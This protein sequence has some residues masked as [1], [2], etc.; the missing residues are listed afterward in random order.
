MPKSIL[1]IQGHPD[2]E[3]R[4]FGHALAESYHAGAAEAGHTVVEIAIATLELPLLRRAEDWAQPTTL[5][6]M[7][8]A[9]K[10]IAAANHLVFIYP[11]WLGDMPAMLK[12]FLE[13][14]SCGGFVMAVDAKGR[15]ERKLDGKSAHIIV[16]MGMPAF[17][18]RWYFMAH[19]LK[20][21]A[22]NILGFSG[23]SP[24]ATSIVGSVDGE[25]SAPHRVRWLEK[26]RAAGAAAR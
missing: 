12:V 2:A 4:H 14:V 16:T 23:V 8:A 26:M 21:F 5:P 7:L 25:A 13:Q 10:A 3:R 20:S 9:Q 17:V 15:W 22:R 11:L 6:G 24:I 1:I 18:Y 19:S